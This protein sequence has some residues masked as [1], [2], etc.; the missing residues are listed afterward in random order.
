[1]L[2]PNERERLTKAK[3][4]LMVLSN[5]SDISAPIKP[6]PSFRGLLCPDDSDEVVKAH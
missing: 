4:M 2:N 3:V 6:E 1:M 5:V